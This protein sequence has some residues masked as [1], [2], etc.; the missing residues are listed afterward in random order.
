MVLRAVGESC[1]FGVSK[2]ERVGWFSVTISWPP[3]IR[4]RVAFAIYAGSALATV[5]QIAVSWVF[6]EPVGRKPA[7]SGKNLVQLLSRFNEL[8]SHGQMVSFCSRP[9]AF[10]QPVVRSKTGRRSH[11]IC[12]RNAIV[13]KRNGRSR[14]TVSRDPKVGS[15]FRLMKTVLGESRLQHWILDS[16]SGC[17][18]RRGRSAPERPDRAV[19]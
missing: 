16:I 18:Q 9:F 15:S 6:N 7:Q 5:F 4:P 19:D 10:M 1:S 2:C 11:Q 17:K 3:A 14:D 12:F 13:Q 8:D